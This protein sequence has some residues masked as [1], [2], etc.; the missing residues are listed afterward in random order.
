MTTWFSIAGW[1]FIGGV[2]R[3]W[4]GLQLPTS[5]NFP[6]ATIIVNLLG[7]GFLAWLSHA[8]KLTAG[9]PSAL[10]VGLGVGG[11]GAFTTFSTF[12]VDS[13][14]MLMTQQWGLAAMYMGLTVVG[15][16]IMS[17]LGVWVA[18]RWFTFPVVER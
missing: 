3:Y 7:S 13:L 1:A 5:P 6:W 4:L 8:K 9:W 17:G 11:V 15:G 12:S 18:R 10:T 2:L 14:K 16:F